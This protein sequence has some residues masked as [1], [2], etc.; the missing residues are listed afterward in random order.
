MKSF[1]EYVI[2]YRGAENEKGIFAEAVF[3]DSLF[4][5]SSESFHDISQYVE[6]QTDPDMKTSIFDEIWQEYETKYNL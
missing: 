2:T 3:N 5:R 6:M 1:Y 4:P